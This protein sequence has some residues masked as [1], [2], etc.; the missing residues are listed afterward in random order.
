MH[1]YTY[2]RVE[3]NIWV[4]LLEY[5]YLNTM[6]MYVKQ[7][8]CKYNRLANCYIVCVPACTH[9]C[10][11]CNFSVIGCRKTQK[12]VLG[13]RVFV[14]SF[15]VAG[16]H[17][18]HVCT[19]VMHFLRVEYLNILQLETTFFFW[20]MFKCG[21]SIGRKNSCTMCVWVRSKIR[22]H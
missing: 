9:M 22:A 17:C 18:T 3:Y 13:M 4:H 6:Y 11:C 14:R 2:L 19:S 10:G 1:E 8:W 7:I 20:I 5:T 21:C 16:M 15:F 12:N